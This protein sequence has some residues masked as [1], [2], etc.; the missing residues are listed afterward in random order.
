MS[1]P[2]D[3]GTCTGISRARWRTILGFSVLLVLVTVVAV[4]VT[5]WVL[6][7]GIAVAAAIA[8]GAAV[9]PPDPVAVEAVAEPVGLT[10]TSPIR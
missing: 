1:S 9:A 3:L 10:R 2:N 7:P 4:A 8:L 5:A 6:V